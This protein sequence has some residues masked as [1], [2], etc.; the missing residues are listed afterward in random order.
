MAKTFYGKKNNART[1]LASPLHAGD[2]TMTVQS[3]EQNRLPLTFPFQ[4]TVFYLGDDPLAG[5]IL[6]VT[7]YV[8]GSS[9]NS[10]YVTRG[11]EN[12]NALDFDPSIKVVVVKNEITVAQMAEY[13]TFMNTHD[14]SGGAQGT[15]L[16]FDSLPSGHIELWPL[17]T[18]PTA[19]YVAVS[20][21]L[22]NKISYPNLF[23]LY[24]NAFAQTGD[25]DA[26]KFR[27]PPWNNGRVIIGGDGVTYTVNQ[28][29]GNSTV[30]LT[31]THTVANHSHSISA[32]GYHNHGGGTGGAGG[33]SH[34][35]GTDSQGYHN[36]TFTTSAG[37]YNGGLSSN[38]YTQSTGQSPP[39]HYHNGTVDGN[40]N[41]THNLNINGVGDHAHG[42]GYDANH[43]HGG[44]TGAVAPATDSQLAV[45]SVI[46]PFAVGFYYVRA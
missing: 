14:H 40:G 13:E 36:H 22:V 46:Q 23:T 10:Y 19:N 41:H 9:N 37:I 4:A 45:T 26:T 16:G 11:T 29:G 17:A 2:S 5:E 12:T 15:P 24:G 39:G 38:V 21:Q 34:S 3:G 20:G 18:P 32:D 31:H 44:A 43:A 6:T 25:S 7:G 28:V 42:I 27:L 1:T 35:G 8:G 33:H 30:N